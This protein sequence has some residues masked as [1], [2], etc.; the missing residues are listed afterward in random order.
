MP[1][2]EMIAEHVLFDGNTLGI[3]REFDAYAPAAHANGS[4]PSATH[5]H[6]LRG[7][8]LGFSSESL[9]RWLAIRR[10]HARR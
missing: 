6:A 9:K 10:R 7:K 1:P 4:E 5:F 2:R 3:L 8:D